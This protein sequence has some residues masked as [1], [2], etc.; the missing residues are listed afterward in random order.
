M[1]YQRFRSIYPLINLFIAKPSHLPFCK[2]SAQEY[3]NQSNNLRIANNYILGNPIESRKPVKAT[4]V[5]EKDQT[6]VRVG[7]FRQ[8]Y[9]EFL[10]FAPIII[11][12]FTSLDK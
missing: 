12:L 9:Q 8:H 1:T 11:V 2:I 6:G 3:K 10:T 7:R 4:Q 5:Y